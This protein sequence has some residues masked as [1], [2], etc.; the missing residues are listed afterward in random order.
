MSRPTPAPSQR[1]REPVFRTLEIIAHTLVRV[2]GL[3]LRFTGVDNIPG[4]G[5]GGAVLTVN[6]TGYVDFI[7]AALGVYRA[8]RR[9]RFMI[10]SEVM[11]IAVMRFLVNHT[12]TVPVDRS[13]GSQAY[14][15]AV[16]RLRAGEVVAVYPEATISR[17]FE[18]KDFK[19]GAVRMAADAGVPIVPAIVWGAQRQWTKGGRRNMGRSRIPV[20]VTFGTPL[21]VAPDADVTA[22]TARLH[23]VMRRMLLD[24]QQAYG[25]HP[26]GEFWVPA[27][28]GGS[29]PT[30]EEAAVI[31]DAEARRK[32]EARARKAAEPARGWWRRKL[33][34]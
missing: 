15:A 30:R 18:L 32:A 26:A 12:G 21:T 22:E 31:E 29:A 1:R 24:A 3:D 7:P 23:E 20:S 33:G 8:G 10:K 11:K 19:T 28:L 9:T 17:S 6:H 2:Q 14:H 5:S 16:E 4:H 25:P 34:R 27:R 13:A